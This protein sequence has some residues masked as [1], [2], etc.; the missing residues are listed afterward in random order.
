MAWLSFSSGR[1]HGAAIRRRGGHRWRGESAFCVSPGAGKQSQ[2]GLTRL[3]SP[4]TPV[5]QAAPDLLCLG[6]RGASGRSREGCRLACG[7]RRMRSRCRCR[8]APGSGRQVTTGGRR[9]ARCPLGGGKRGNLY[10]FSYRR[11]GADRA[12]HRDRAGAARPPGHG[13]RSRS[14]AG[15]RPVAGPQGRDAVPSP[16]PFPSAGRRCAAG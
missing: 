1:A 4:G 15:R 16:A 9:R 3:A 11:G 13:D 5:Y 7:D 14:R 8:R 10:A 12:V 6:E 2:A